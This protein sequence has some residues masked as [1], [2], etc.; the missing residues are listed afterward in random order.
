MAARN[1]GL[2]MAIG[3]VAPLALA[4]AVTGEASGD[5]FILDEHA[6]DGAAWIVW[7]FH[8]SEPNT[9]V[10]WVYDGVFSGGSVGHHGHWVLLPD[11]FGGWLEH[12]P[13]AAEHASVRAA[14]LSIVNINVME[15][16]EL[17]QNTYFSTLQPGDHHLVSVV[18]SNGRFDGTVTLMAEPGV[19][20]LGKTTG[21]PFTFTDEDLS[22]TASAKLRVKAHL[23]L[24]TKATVD[25]W[26]SVD[27]KDTLWGS[28]FVRDGGLEQYEAS[29]QGPNGAGGESDSTRSYYMHAF[30]GAEPGTY[31][32]Q[33][34]KD[35]QARV[36]SGPF[37]IVYGA[38]VHY[39]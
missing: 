29:W 17:D 11:A 35:V 24:M 19:E 7:K 5:L 37:F 30:E 15:E 16:Y 26:A 13:T 36:W 3:L 31:T 23:S 25:G 1:L 8:V 14:D 10:E 28:M 32:F 34:H 22:S 12:G 4:G 9:N 18:G 21:T 38:D 2:M 6:I 20:I 27:I 33:L 39:P